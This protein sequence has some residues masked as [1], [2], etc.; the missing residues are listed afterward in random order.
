MS[1]STNMDILN[2]ID[3][4]VRNIKSRLSEDFDVNLIEKQ[5]QQEKDVI[6]IEISKIGEF[7]WNLYAK[8]EIDV[9]ENIVGVFKEIE[10]H[11]MKIKDLKT[12][13]E[14]RKVAGTEE[15]I[16]IDIL[17][18]EKEERRTAKK[19]DHKRLQKNKH[20]EEKIVEEN[21]SEQIEE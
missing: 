20:S 1:R 13:I 8:N 16:Q 19:D 12:Q 4:K 17:T 5:I 18:K 21:I 15:R 10:R 14:N 6:D 2:R 11:I 9:S 7:Y 3:N